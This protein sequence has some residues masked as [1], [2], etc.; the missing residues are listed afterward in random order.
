M[1]LRT[2]QEAPPHWRL[3]SWLVPGQ[4]RRWCELCVARNQVAAMLRRQ[5]AYLGDRRNKH[6]NAVDAVRNFRLTS[7]APAHL[8]RRT[9]VAPGDALL[10]LARVG[11]FA[12]TEERIRAWDRCIQAN[13][14][15]ALSWPARMCLIRS[16]ALVAKSRRTGWCGVEA[17]LLRAA[18][19]CT[20]QGIGGFGGLPRYSRLTRGYR[21]SARSEGKFRVAMCA[22]AAQL[23]TPSF[24]A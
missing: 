22:A 8:P 23:C 4:A 12:G 14:R 15:N 6:T 21:A 11:G 16:T 1:N 10:G 20:D 7:A 13:R 18:N 19:Y 17:G 3:L 9:G 2:K 5:R 24:S